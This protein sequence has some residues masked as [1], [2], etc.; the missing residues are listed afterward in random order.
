[1]IDAAR[2]WKARAAAGCAQ[3]PD[4]KPQASPTL[5]TSTAWQSRF[6]GRGEKVLFRETKETKPIRQGARGSTS[7]LRDGLEL[8]AVA[9]HHATMHPARWLLNAVEC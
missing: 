2:R 6:N 8:D 7:R 5:T 1:M 3:A 4:Q 9:G